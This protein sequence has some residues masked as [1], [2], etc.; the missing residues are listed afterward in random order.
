M[1]TSYQNFFLLAVSRAGRTDL[2]TNNEVQK[3]PR[4][5]KSARVAGGGRHQREGPDQPAQCWCGHCSG[6]T[7]PSGGSYSRR[8]VLFLFFTLSMRAIVAVMRLDFF[9]KHM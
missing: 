2:H 4:E 3:V 5:P 9:S 6:D 7:G 1:T 8:Y